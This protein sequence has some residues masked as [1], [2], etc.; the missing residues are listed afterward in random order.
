MDRRELLA[1]LPAVWVAG[2]T[3][4]DP[5]HP[6]DGAP[7]TPD[8][9]SETPGSC[10]RA[11]G[12]RR[13]ATGACGARFEHVGTSPV[14]TATTAPGGTPYEGTFDDHLQ[15]TVVARGDEALELRGCIEGRYEAEP[16]RLGVR[17]SLPAEPDEH[18][19]EF[20]PFTHPGGIDRYHLWIRGCDAEVR[21]ST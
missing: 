10:E 8:S 14:S 11:F 5:G 18:G 7:A 1:A 2:C 16:K 15:V 21:G 19:F 17:R 12:D 20:G 9:P 6:P 3:A 4:A 13:T